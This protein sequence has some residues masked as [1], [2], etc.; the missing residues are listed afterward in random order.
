MAMAVQKPFWKNPWFLAGFY[1]ILFL[2]VI[3]P[4]MRN[5][6]DP[7]PVLGTVSAPELKRAN[8]QL[9]GTDYFGDSLTIIGFFTADCDE[10]CETRLGV[11]MD[12]QREL[13]YALGDPESIRITLVENPPVTPPD[14]LHAFAKNRSLHTER[15]DWLTGTEAHVAQLLEQL[16]PVGP[17]PIP[18]IENGEERKKSPLLESVFLVDLEGGVRGR[19][20]GDSKGL[21][22]VFHRSR[23]V[24]FNEKH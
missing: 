16:D 6:P 24:L 15:W 8:G 23:H 19:Y 4:F 2:A 11:L 7:P 9:T 14:Q 3:R 18:N 13:D 5:V 20:S 12:L 10:A 17:P 22:E 1:G 21:A